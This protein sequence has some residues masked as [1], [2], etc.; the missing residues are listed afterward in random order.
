M[1][2]PVSNPANP[3]TSHWDR[4]YEGAVR[5]AWTQNPQVAAELYQRMT[6]Q[7]GFWMEWVFTQGLPPV[8]KLLSIG[9]GDGGHEIAMAQ[10]SFAKHIRAFDAS[11]VA[12]EQAKAKAVAG[13]L[14]VDFFVG[15]FEAFVQDPGPQDQYDAV[16]F[17]GSLHHVL[18][19]E[20]MLSAVRHVLK[21]GGRVVV[22][23]YCG[24]CYQLYG[25]DQLDLVNRVLTSVPEA[26]KL[27]PDIQLALP[28]IEMIMGGDPTE[29]VRAPLIPV[30]VPMYFRK[31]YE[32][33][34]GGALLHP[35]FGCLNGAKVNDGSPESLAFVQMLILLENELT[36]AGKLPHEFLFGI[37]VN[38]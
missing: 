14:D 30:L 35:L 10:R 1:S 38:D 2:Q 23:E 28:T 13:G 4:M 27:G 18:D 16:V 29:G 8:D 24:P 26:F 36:A 5:S 21:P 3:S 31:E 19:L 33:F 9:C 22:N 37:Y 25:K 12:I 17:S 34:V 6:D 15:T 7:P 20:G 32:R 11:P